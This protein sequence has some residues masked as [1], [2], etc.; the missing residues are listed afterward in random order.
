M[1]MEHTDCNTNHVLTSDNGAIWQR[2]TWPM[3]DIMESTWGWSENERTSKL[4]GM[5]IATFATRYTARQLSIMMNHWDVYISPLSLSAILYNNDNC[6]LRT[7]DC[8]SQV[9]FCRVVSRIVFF[10]LHLCRL[11]CLSFAFR[12]LILILRAVL[13]EFR[14][15][16]SAIR[17][18]TRLSFPF[19]CF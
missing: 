6:Q 17:F 1:T 14:F 3:K 10:L 11:Q 13:S 9:S 18:Q 16:Q 12:Y 2:Q 5:E 4:I 15:F 7:G 19:H 8:W